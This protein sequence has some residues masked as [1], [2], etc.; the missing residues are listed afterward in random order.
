MKSEPGRPDDLDPDD[1]DDGLHLIH[2]EA[3]DQHPA[4]SFTYGL[5]RAFKHPEVAV[6]GLE[7]E[8]ADDLLQA[9]ADD[10]E[11]GQRFAAGETRDGIVHGYPVWFGRVG[12]QQVRALLEGFDGPLGAADVT[13]L[14]VVYPDRQGRWPWQED[15]RVGFRALQPVLEREPGADAG[16]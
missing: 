14:Q 8:T 3:S 11:D 5:W 4:Y 16:A 1:L 15:V 13:M 9:I 12:A 10:V 7:P 2:V 6:F